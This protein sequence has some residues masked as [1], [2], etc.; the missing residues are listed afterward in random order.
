MPS[1]KWPRNSVTSCHV[2]RWRAQKDKKNAVRENL[3]MVPN[4]TASKSLTGSSYIWP[5]VIH[6]TAKTQEHILYIGIPT[7]LFL[8]NQTAKKYLV[9]GH[10]YL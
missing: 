1:V 3:A 7:H 6:M 4:V 8:Q 10:E 2:R 5:Y 9:D